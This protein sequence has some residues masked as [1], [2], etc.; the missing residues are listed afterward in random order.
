[1][2]RAVTSALIL[3]LAAATSDPLAGRVAGPPQDCIDA[4]VGGPT[5]IDGHSVIYGLSA[6][7]LYRAE[8]ESCPSLRPFTTLVV[9]MF[10]SRLCRND[11]FRVLEPNSS[12]PSAYCRFSAFTPYTRV[13]ARSD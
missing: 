5:I 11:R 10:G 4:S 1:M 7:T 8:V 12:I 9:E 13:K 2:I 6:R 3:P